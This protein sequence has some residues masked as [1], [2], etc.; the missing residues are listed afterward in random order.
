LRSF[1]GESNRQ[2]FSVARETREAI[3][4]LNFAPGGNARNAPKH[5][6]PDEQKWA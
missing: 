5:V 4:A 3:S 2:Q 1:D 6:K